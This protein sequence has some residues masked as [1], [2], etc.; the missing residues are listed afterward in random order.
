M[1]RRVTKKAELAMTKASLD[2]KRIQIEIPGAETITEADIVAYME[3]H[4]AA[5]DCGG[6]G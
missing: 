5:S 3:Q 1:E 2:M 4:G 6:R